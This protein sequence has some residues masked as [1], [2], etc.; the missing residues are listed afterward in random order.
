MAPGGSLW[1]C[2]VCRRYVV[3]EGQPKRRRCRWCYHYMSRRDEGRWD[4][5]IWAEGELIQEEE[6]PP[7]RP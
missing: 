2:E 6:P 1:Y 3:L 4:R 7:A 5:F